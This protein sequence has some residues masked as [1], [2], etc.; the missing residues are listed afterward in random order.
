MFTF[1]QLLTYKRVVETGSFNKAASESFISVNAVM[2]QINNLENEVG[3]QLLLRSNSRVKL[4]EPGISF[5]E[6]TLKIL[7]S[8]DGAIQKAVALSNNSITIRVGTSVANPTDKL[9]IVLAKMLVHHPNIK[10]EMIPFV[11][12]SDAT[13]SI[14]SNLGERI[15]IVMSSFDELTKAYWNYETLEIGKVP[16]CL[17]VPVSHRLAS[18]KLASFSDLS[19][20][21]LMIVRRGYSLC[22]DKTRTHIEANYPDINII[23]VPAFG[24]DLYNKVANVD[25]LM[26]GIGDNI[27]GHPLTKRIPLDWDEKSPLGI[28]YS[29]KP[30]DQV[31]TFI[32]MIRNYI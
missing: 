27:K 20:E 21:D 3:V 19:G 7:S 6:D 18:A 8:C 13:A 1:N 14:Y 10:I 2:K 32:Q 11:N 23:D 12:T 15:D 25:T 17:I 4:T 22:L 26:L 28:L 24:I 29:K 30:S 9:D 16:L 31:K 5:Y